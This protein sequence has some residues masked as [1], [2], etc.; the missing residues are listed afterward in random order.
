M[1][2]APPPG[3]AGLTVIELM[4]ALAIVSLLATVGVSRYQDYRERVRVSTA[5]TDIGAMSVAISHY[6]LDNHAPPDS[7]AA[8]GLAGRVDPWGKPYQYYNLTN[9]KGNGKARKDKKLNPLNSDF[10]LYSMGK[11]G[12]SSSSLQA[13]WSR[14]DVVRARDG[15]FVGLAS[16]FDP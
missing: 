16:D 9:S 14:D 13:K 8:V 5:I 4:I 10:D 2:T 6:T 11:D 3:V 12:Y 1:R 15:A 7:L